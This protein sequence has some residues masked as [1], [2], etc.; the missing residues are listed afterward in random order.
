[1]DQVV[2]EP[3]AAVLTDIP[4]IDAKIKDIPSE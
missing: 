2:I 3:E 1:M 4:M